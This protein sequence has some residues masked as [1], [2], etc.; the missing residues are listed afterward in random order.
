MAASIEWAFQCILAKDYTRMPSAA[1]HIPQEDMILCE[2][3]GYILQGLPDGA[4]CPECGRPASDSTDP[5][6][7]RLPAW[8]QHPSPATFLTTS[9]K[10]LFMPTDFYRHLITRRPSRLSQVFAWIWLAL[11]SGLFAVAGAGHAA[12]LEAKPLSWGTPPL[13]LIGIYVTAKFLAVPLLFFAILATMRIAGRLTAW[14]AAYRGLRLPIHVVQRGLDYHTVHMLPV[15]F[16]A[17]AT[18]SGYHLLLGTG[19]LTRVW[20]TTYLWLLCGEVVVCAVYLFVTYWAAM[21]GMLY[22]NR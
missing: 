21:R 8:E 10:V 5:L 17:M 16:V 13:W 11:C 1:K 4:R 9:A 6:L 20:D 12:W 7:R 19:K 2:G 18:V 3:C 15:A 14:E 22:A